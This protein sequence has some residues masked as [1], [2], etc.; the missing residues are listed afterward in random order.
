MF[1]ESENN[2]RVTS[3]KRSK[4]HSPPPHLK[5]ALDGTNIDQTNESKTKDQA[6][7]TL[8][9]ALFEERVG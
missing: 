4:S 2:R 5:A 3:H 7:I 6:I 9:S 8:G 1:Q